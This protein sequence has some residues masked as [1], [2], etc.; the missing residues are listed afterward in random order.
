MIKGGVLYVLVTDHLGSVRLVVNASTGGVVQRIDYDAWGEATLVTGTWDEQPF[1]FAGG[2]YDAHTKLVHFGAREYDA[3]TGRWTRGDPILFS[4][5]DTNLYSYVG[6]DPVNFYDEDGLDS[7]ATSTW[8][9]DLAMLAAGGAALGPLLPVVGGAAVGTGVILYCGAVV[10]SDTQ[11][12]EV[13]RKDGPRNGRDCEARYAMDIATC[14]GIG[15][16]DKSRAARCYESA[17]NRLIACEQGRPLPP[18]HGW[19]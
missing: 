3:E 10:M 16:Q 12:Q 17:M 9:R 4:G 1:G 8:L 2:M 14:R 5:G 7:T 13:A 15:Q 11:P 19:N 18:L 6:G